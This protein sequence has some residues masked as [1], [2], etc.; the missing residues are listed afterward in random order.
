MH[1]FRYILADK[2]NKYFMFIN[3]M[4]VGRVKYLIALKNV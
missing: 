1:L 2:S 3:A 4:I